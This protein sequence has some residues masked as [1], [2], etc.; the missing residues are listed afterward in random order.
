M[1]IQVPIDS[2]NDRSFIGQEFKGNIIKKKH[3]GKYTCC[4]KNILQHVA[5]VRIILYNNVLMLYIA[6]IHCMQVI[7]VWPVA[8]SSVTPVCP[9]GDKFSP[10]SIRVAHSKVFCIIASELS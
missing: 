5:C 4:N 8:P 6:V 9:H 1:P 2:Y 7:V 3:L 10:T